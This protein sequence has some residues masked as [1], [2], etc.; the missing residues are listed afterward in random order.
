MN[1]IE[2]LKRI[3]KTLSYAKMGKA[4]GVS[5]KSVY[6]WVNGLNSPSGL[7]LEKIRKLISKN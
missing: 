7:A 2:E 5:K 6:R 4:L 1:T 3:N